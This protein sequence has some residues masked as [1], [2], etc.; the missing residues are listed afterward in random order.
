MT[1][2]NKPEPARGN[3]VQYQ[4]RETRRFIVTRYSETEDT[5]GGS[6]QKGEYADANVA[7]EVAYA[8]CK[9]ENDAAG[10]ELCGT[11]FAYPTHPDE[12][13]DPVVKLVDLD[14]LNQAQG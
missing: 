14:S 13:A 10:T 4:V 5:V 1:L 9:S 11:R 8:L 6:V 2:H 7:Y 12:H 3:I